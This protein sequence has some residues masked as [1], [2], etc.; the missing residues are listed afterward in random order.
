MFLSSSRK[1]KAPAAPVA[2]DIVPDTKGRRFSLPVFSRKYPSNPKRASLPYGP[3]SSASD[4]MTSHGPF[5]SVATSRSSATSR[6]TSYTRAT[7]PLSAASEE[8]AAP[9]LEVDES[10]LP[11]YFSATYPTKPVAYQ[12]LQ[13]SPFAMTITCSDEDIPGTGKYHVSIG[14]NVWMP[15]SSVTTIKRNGE[16]G[17]FVARLELGITTDQATVTTVNYTRPV[18]DVLYRKST[19]SSSRLYYIDECNAIKW[20]LGESVWQAHHGLTHLATFTPTFP[21]KLILQ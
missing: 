10:G 12:F 13:V 1:G 21:R 17:P 11:T 14:L 20:R 8:A 7:S 3:T 15:S 9:V 16:D 4:G 2:V 18:K 5:G 19:F 6:R